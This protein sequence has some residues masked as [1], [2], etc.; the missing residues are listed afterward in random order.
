MWKVI[1]SSH[2]ILEAPTNRPQPV[3]NRC[4]MPA[5]Y[6]INSS[7]LGMLAI[8]AI[9]G[10]HVLNAGIRGQEPN[11]PAEAAS[12]ELDSGKLDHDLP[13]FEPAEVPVFDALP[14]PQSVADELIEIRRR[15]GNDLILGGEF[16]G[17]GADGSDSATEQQQ[18]RDQLLQFAGR[19]SDPATAEIDGQYASESSEDRAS[20]RQQIAIQHAVRAIY[21]TADQL[22]AAGC[23]T[24]AGEVRRLAERLATQPERPAAKHSTAKS[25]TV[26]DALLLR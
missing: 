12:L 7:A 14:A 23:T 5:K 25:N 2:A 16:E 4:A 22:I 18:L 15:L 13:S 17:F 10:L 21:A 1:Y 19:A 6:R 26:D 20:K 24:E 3:E 9:G 8:A 11:N